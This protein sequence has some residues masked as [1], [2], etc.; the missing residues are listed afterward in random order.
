MS[1]QV[2]R[3]VVLAHGLRQPPLEASEEIVEPA[4]AVAVRLRHPIFLHGII[5]VTAG[6]FISTTSVAQGS[7]RRR[8]PVSTSARVNSFCSSTSS[9]TSTGNGQPTFAA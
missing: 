7:R 5:M 1:L 9:V 8:R 4:V 3:D 2:A 6:F